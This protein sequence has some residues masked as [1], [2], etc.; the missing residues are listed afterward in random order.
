[1][2]DYYKVLDLNYDASLDEIKNSF[3]HKMKEYKLYP[4][5]TDEDKKKIK[6]LKKAYIVLTNS[7]FKSTYDTN[8]KNKMNNQ[9]NYITKTRKGN[10]N[11]S[12]ISDRIFNLNDNYTE[13]KTTHM[14]SFIANSEI[15]RPKNSILDS[16]SKIDYDTP[17][18]FEKPTELQPFNYDT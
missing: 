7:E 15:L 4:F 16:E 2:D 5:L 11:N 1:M 10:M 18:N 14:N 13:I 6:T 3:N 9:P 12:Y 17:L 8:I